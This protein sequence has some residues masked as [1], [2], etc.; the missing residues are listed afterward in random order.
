MKY[1]I[2]GAGAAGLAFACQLKRKG[3]N[4]FLLIEKE[5]E[6]GGLCRSMMVDG[7]PLD[8]GGGHFLDVKRPKVNEFL[9]SYLPKDEW[10]LFFRDSKIDMKEGIISHPLEA[11]LWQMRLEEQVEYLIDIS[12]AGCN[13]DKPMPEKFIDWIRWKLGDR[14]AENYMLPYNRKMFSD[15][16]NDLGTYWLEKLPNVSFR[17]TLLS[18]LSHKAYG[19]QPGHASFYYPKRYGYGEVWRR[20]ANS[21]S[22]HI[23]YETEVTGINCATREVYSKSGKR[24]QSD[25]IITTI[26]W[27][28]FKDIYEMPNEIVNSIRRLKSTAIE[29]RYCSQ[30]MD[31]E[32]QWIYYPQECLPY[33]RILVRHNFCTN[34]RGYWMETR[35]ERVKMFGEENLGDT[36]SYINE[37]AY[38]L[39]TLDKPRIMSDLLSYAMDKHI[40]GLGRWGEHSHYNSDFTVERAL[41]LADSLVMI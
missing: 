40:Y 29:T 1:I 28:C 3:E 36:F 22:G 14:I 17:E 12:K 27:N 8:I 34:S 19:K 2:L 41:Q 39:N 37:Y 5:R 20:M 23:C 25:I 13:N 30:N 9:F 6:A 32:A 24:F 33:H 16:L 31:T 7:S 15:N 38:P 21:L 10:Q 35:G 4:D 26:P 18:C 11:N